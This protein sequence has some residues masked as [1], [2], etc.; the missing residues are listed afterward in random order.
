ML[1]AIDKE[2]NTILHKVVG[3]RDLITV[4]FLLEKRINVNK[5]NVKGE[6]ALIQ[7]I[8]SSSVEIMNAL[9]Y[10]GAS[11]DLLDNEGQGLAYHL[12]QNYRAPRNGND[13]FVEKLK[14]LKEK[15][16]DLKKHQK[17]EIPYII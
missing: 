5:V 11:I 17:K 3:G 14:W 6:S 9:V 15:G 7:A 10:N 16:V 4:N 13:D 12:V 2:G 1:E 8:K